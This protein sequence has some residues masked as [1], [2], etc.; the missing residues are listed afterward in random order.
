MHFTFNCEK[1]ASTVRGSV[2]E[3]RA[4]KYRVSR[5]VKLVARDSGISCTQPYIR[6]PITSADSAVP[7]IANVNMAP[8]LRKK[9]FCKKLISSFLFLLCHINS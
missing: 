4:P 2:G 1:M 3:M 6:A 7:T 9:Y 8:R 5:K